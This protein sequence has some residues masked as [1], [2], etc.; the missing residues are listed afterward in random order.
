MLYSK[1]LDRLR[2]LLQL[3]NLNGGLVTWL[4]SMKPLPLPC[5]VLLL[6]MLV[7]YCVPPPLRTTCLLVSVWS[8]AAAPSAGVYIWRADVR[9][10]SP[11]VEGQGK[12]G[13]CEKFIFGCGLG[14]GSL[15]AATHT[16]ATAGSA[17]CVYVC[18]HRACATMHMHTHAR[19]PPDGIGTGESR[20]PHQ[21]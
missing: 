10:G 21:G 20:E 14:G 17:V 13:C 5:I 7:P 3:P 8:S 16:T 18:V 12:R 4:P 6:S 11:N 15:R 9:L 19:G 2:L 1:P